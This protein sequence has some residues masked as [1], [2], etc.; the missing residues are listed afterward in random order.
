MDAGPSL[1]SAPV[2]RGLGHPL[3]P[4]TMEPRYL[5]GGQGRVRGRREGMQGNLG[6]TVDGAR[7]TQKPVKGRGSECICA[8]TGWGE[9]Y[10]KALVIW[11]GG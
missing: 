6:S 9:D 8:L 2:P 7:T 10:R 1:L 3:P 4:P 5:P 11:S